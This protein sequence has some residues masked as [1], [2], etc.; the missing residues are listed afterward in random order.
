[1]KNLNKKLLREISTMKGQVVAIALVMAAVVSIFVMS[2]GVI[3]SLD[4]TRR[5]YYDE[6]RFAD[7]FVGVK[8]AP[9]TLATRIEQIDGVNRV[10]TSVSPAQP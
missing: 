10:T 4:E 2:F 9:E 8:R 5:V 7:V 1:M 6:Y 3:A